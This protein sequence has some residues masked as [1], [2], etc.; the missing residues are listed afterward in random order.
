L[1]V[2]KA[3]RA[4][5]ALAEARA[6]TFEAAA[7]AYFNA[8]E[9][10][11]KNRKHRA[12]FLS[13]LKTYAY[14]KIGKLSVAAIDTG[15]VLKVIEP[16]WHDKTETANRVRGRVEAVLDWATVRGYRVGDNPARWRGHLSEALP[17]R[18]KIQKTVHHAALAYDELPEFMMALSQRDG[19]AA[20]ALEFTILTAARTGE[21]VGATWDEIN[22]EEK[23]WIVPA[24][25]IKGGREHRVP[26]SERALKILHALPTEKDNPFVFIGP[27]R[28]GLSNMAM[29]AVVQ[30]MGRDD[31]TVH[32]FRSTF[33][34]WCAERTNYPNHIVEMALAH[35]VGD[36]VEAAYRRGDLFAKRIKLM[37]DWA[38]FATTKPATESGD[39]VVPMHR[40]P[41]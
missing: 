33:R 19:V 15:L 35:V 6:L 8:H 34:D 25:R 26:L 24:G 21:V 27:R 30:R 16:I 9:R 4:A 29:A 14:P 2:R 3:E 18:E 5:A 11:W 37:A 40:F 32:G 7:Q 38:R 17:A 39:K 23:S 22:L 36:K 1:E 10:G 31:I 41:A 12:Q 28:G 13:T 20:R